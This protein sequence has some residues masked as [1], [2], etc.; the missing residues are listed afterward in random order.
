MLSYINNAAINANTSWLNN[1]ETND[2]E[3]DQAMLEGSYLESSWNTTASGG[4]AY[5]PFQIQL[6]AHP[7][8]SAAQAENPSFA[9]SYMLPSYIAA[10]QQVGQPLWKSNPAAAA[11]ETVLLAERPEN[12]STEVSQLAAGTYPVEYGAETATAVPAAHAA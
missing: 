3:L 7:D 10:I 4:G 12:Y 9:A 1:N 2:V 11:E 5:G 6:N 8:V